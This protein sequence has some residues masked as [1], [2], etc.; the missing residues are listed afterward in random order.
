MSADPAAAVGAVTV[1]GG[2]ALLVGSWTAAIAEASVPPWEARAFVAVNG[3]PD[4]LWPFV[5]VPMQAGSFGGSIAIAGLTAAVTRQPR[6]AGA[7]VAASQAGFWTAKA[8]KKA[9]RRGRPAALLPVV[10]SRESATGLGYVSGHA[11]VSF[12]LAAALA[13]S[14]PR[15]WRPVMFGGATFVGLARQYAGVHLPL[16]VIGGAGVGLL[17]GTISRWAFG[18]GGAGVG[19]R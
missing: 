12:A 18:L 3:L 2:S 19:G 10:R 8:I 15:V 14:A 4:P 1:V 5:W 9:V 7:A 16:D 6:L 13:Q 11:A 17:A